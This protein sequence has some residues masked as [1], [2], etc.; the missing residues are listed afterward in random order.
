MALPSVLEDL[1]WQERVFVTVEKLDDG[2]QVDFAARLTEIGF[3]NGSRDFDVEA[4]ANGGFHR[5]RTAEEPTSFSGEMYVQGPQTN[6]G[7]TE[8]DMKGIAEYFYENEGPDHDGANGVYHYTNGTLARSKFRVTIL[9]TND[10][11]VSSAVD[12]VAS[13]NV[14]YR[15]VIRDANLI[16]YDQNFDDMDSSAEF[17]F[18]TPPRTP[19]ADP[20]IGEWGCEADATSGLNALGAYASGSNVLVDGTSA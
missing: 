15:K 14:A 16:S 20:N 6:A 5:T 7:E 8:E 9:W 13:G 3:D 12:A 17:E 18:K 19:T 10:P 11:N 1:S 2:T 4:L